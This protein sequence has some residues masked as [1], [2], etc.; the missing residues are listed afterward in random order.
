MDASGF[1]STRKVIAAVHP[2]SGWRRVKIER[3][4]RPRL[5]SK[6]GYRPSA[7]SQAGGE[8]CGDRTL[9]QLS[10]ENILVPPPGFTSSKRRS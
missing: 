9:P 10:L 7:H 2:L 5:F 4:G 3:D 8:Y 1:F 6:F